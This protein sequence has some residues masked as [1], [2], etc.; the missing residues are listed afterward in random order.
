M[1][2]LAA[3]KKSSSEET[4]ACM[5]TLLK[6]LLLLS[7]CD[8]KEPSGSGWRSVQIHEIAFNIKYERKPQTVPGASVCYVFMKQNKAGCVNI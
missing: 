6:L 8:D 7:H 4:A 1:G 3:H 5:E 2:L